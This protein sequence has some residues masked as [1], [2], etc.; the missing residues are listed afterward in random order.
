MSGLNARVALACHEFIKTRGSG[1]YC[2]HRFLRTPTGALLSTQWLHKRIAKTLQRGLMTL[3]RELC[4]L[5]YLSKIIVLLGD[6][7]CVTI[8]NYALEQN[9]VIR[10]HAFCLVPFRHWLARRMSILFTLYFWPTSDLLRVN[11]INFTL[12]TAEH[13]LHS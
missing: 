9:R 3:T 12:Y 10:F 4:S 11:F 8:D 6:S 13:M 1:T 2:P 5:T 7:P